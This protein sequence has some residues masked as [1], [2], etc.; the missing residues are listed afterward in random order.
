MQL[1]ERPGRSN[2]PAAAVPAPAPAS[3][4]RSKRQRT[5]A[6]DGG[7]AG[8]QQYSF[9][10][11]PVS[12]PPSTFPAQT[13]RAPQQAAPAGGVAGAGDGGL[14]GAQQYSFPLPPV[15]GPPSTFP[16]QTL[17][18]PQQAAP[19]GGV[20]GAG[21]GGLAGAQQ[22]SFPLPPVSGPPS[23]FPAQTLRAPQQA[24]PAGGVAGAGDGGLAGAQQYSFPLPPGIYGGLPDLV[25]SGAMGL[26]AGAAAP[27]MA[28]VHAQR[29]Q[30]LAV[31]RGPPQPSLMAHEQREPAEGVE[32]AVPWAAAAAG[33][34]GE[35]AGKPAAA[36]IRGQVQH[37]FNAP[38]VATLDRMYSDVM[39]VRETARAAG[40]LDRLPWQQGFQLEQ[41]VRARNYVVIGDRGR[42]SATLWLRRAIWTMTRYPSAARS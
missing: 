39:V 3:A 29:R 41:L 27:A 33:V 25:A 2:A 16:A 38:V 20:A 5:G 9:P 15:S 35:Q 17:R 14:A 22:Y 21:D 19:A 13:L 24:A 8:A 30:P 18:A 36:M 1:R 37:Q 28:V 11:P 40:R 34:G 4:G 31:I 42:A 32:N 6:G 7:L 26:A 10:L 12:G 23:T